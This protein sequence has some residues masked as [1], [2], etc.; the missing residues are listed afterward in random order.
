MK[1]M[2]HKFALIICAGTMLIAS[3]P[4]FAYFGPGAGITMLGAIWAVIAAVFLA[5]AGSG[6][7]SF[8]VMLRRRKKAMNYVKGRWTAM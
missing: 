8:R 1:P 7:P 6:H 3:G 4:A 2:R 5:V